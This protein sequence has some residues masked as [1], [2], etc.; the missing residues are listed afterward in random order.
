MFTLAR[1]KKNSLQGGSSQRKVRRAYWKQRSVHKQNLNKI[2]ITKEEVKNFTRV[3]FYSLPKP[4]H[5]V[6]TYLYSEFFWSAFPRI[7]TEYRKTQSISPYS[8]RMR[9]NT[10]TRKNPN[11]DTFHTVILSKHVVNLKKEVKTRL[12][13]QHAL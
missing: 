6:E 13:Q 12:L 2:Q 7:R 11:T 8:V 9:E 4:I 1:F 5:R 10:K 3:P